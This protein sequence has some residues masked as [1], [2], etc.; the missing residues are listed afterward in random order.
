MR[1][2]IQR[3]KG[4]KVS[5]DE[6]FVGTIKRGIL[7]FLGVEKEDK[8]EDADYLVSKA[9]HLRI[10]EDKDG[11]MNLSLK[12]VNGE[13]LVISQFTLLGDCRKGRRPSFTDAAES[14]KARELYEYFVS[15][16]ES[17]DISVATGEFQAKMDVHIVNNGPVTL[18]LD[19]R[20]R[21]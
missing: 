16:M 4:S 1:A 7:I 14:D 10:F 9:I 2:V 13:V 21:F 12:G 20:K 6:K 11:K 5:V 18:L 15:Q 17:Y 8:E 19:S 3:V